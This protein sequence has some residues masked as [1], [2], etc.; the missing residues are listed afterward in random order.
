MD[1]TIKDMIY[2]IK[3]DLGKNFTERKLIT[4]LY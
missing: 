1:T 4:H 2:G 3:E